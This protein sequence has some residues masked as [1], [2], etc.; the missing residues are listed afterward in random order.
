MTISVG[1]TSSNHQFSGDM[2]VFRGVRIFWTPNLKKKTIIMKNYTIAS[3]EIWVADGEKSCEWK[4]GWWFQPIWT[5]W[6]NMDHSP[7]RGENKNLWKPPPWNWYQNKNLKLQ[8]IQGS[9]LNESYR[10]RRVPFPACWSQGHKPTYKQWAP[11]MCCIK[12]K[13]VEQFFCGIYLDDF[14]E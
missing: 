1:N 2:L 3:T 11:S 12:W 8:R 10:V 9:G 5:L 13:K 6:V 7:N 4:S 14:C